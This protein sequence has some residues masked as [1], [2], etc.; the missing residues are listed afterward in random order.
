MLSEMQA[1][2]LTGEDDPDSLST[3]SGRAGV[4][5]ASRRKPTMEPVPRAVQGWIRA[6][7]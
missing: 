4:A 7:L 5:L 3:R 6:R 2:S 1:S